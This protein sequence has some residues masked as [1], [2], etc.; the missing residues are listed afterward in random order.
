MVESFLS[1]VVAF[2]ANFAFG[3]GVGSSISSSATKAFVRAILVSGVLGMSQISFICRVKRWSSSMTVAPRSV[4]AHGPAV[5]TPISHCE[6]DRVNNVDRLAHSDE[7][8]CEA[9][10][11][12]HGRGG[13]R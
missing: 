10:R 4:R 7:D 3:G 8:S 9:A 5:R 1:R 13:S 2:D 12:C 11:K 6:D